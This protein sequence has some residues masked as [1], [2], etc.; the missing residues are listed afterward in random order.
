MTRGLV[1]A[2]RIKGA[3]EYL[4]YGDTYPYRDRIAKMGGTFRSASKNWRVSRAV[5]DEIHASVQVLARVAAHCHTPEEILHL[6]EGVAKGGFV[7]L[8]C[9][10]CDRS[11][12]DGDRVAVLEILG[13]AETEDK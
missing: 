8:S 9:S 12:W 11:S 5:V 7:Q 1:F 2:K 4:L 13:E 10:L 3:D 6:N